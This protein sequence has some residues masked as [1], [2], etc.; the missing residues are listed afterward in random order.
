MVIRATR[1]EAILIGQTV[2]AGLIRTAREELA[3]EIAPIDDFRST[4]L[5]RR[6]VA[7]NLLEDFLRDLTNGHERS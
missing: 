2:D 1:T 3:A 7:Q 6:C 5:Y 4:A